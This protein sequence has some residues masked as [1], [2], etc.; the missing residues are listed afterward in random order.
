MMLVGNLDIFTSSK[1]LLE[2]EVNHDQEIF[3]NGLVSFILSLFV[4]SFVFFIYFEWG[5]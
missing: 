3:T 4:I 2:Q 5:I 1:W